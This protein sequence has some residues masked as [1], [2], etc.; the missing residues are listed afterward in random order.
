MCDHTL[1]E[2]LRVVRWPKYYLLVAMWP[3]HQLTVGKCPLHYYLM[4]GKWLAPLLPGRKYSYIRNFWGLYALGSS[5]NT[6]KASNHSQRQA[7]FSVIEA[8]STLAS[9]IHDPINKSHSNSKFV[10]LF[11]T[12]VNLDPPICP[13]PPLARD[14]GG[15]RTSSV[16]SVSSIICLT[17]TS[18]PNR[19]GRLPLRLPGVV[20]GS[21]RIYRL[22][23]KYI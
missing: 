11:K 7:T 22:E 3:T 2:H 19:R 13:I 18:E 20:K 8:W 6:K 16:S 14:A 21:I 10:P 17:S 15:G 5:Y 12:A 23:S 9:L 4:I 1:K